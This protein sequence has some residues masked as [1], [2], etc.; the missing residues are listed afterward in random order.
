MPRTGNRRDVTSGAVAPLKTV[1][2]DFKP[3]KGSLGS[4]AKRHLCV[5]GLRKQGHAEGSGFRVAGLGSLFPYT[6]SPKP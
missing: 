2:D 3:H 1:N 4:K 5:T 6:L